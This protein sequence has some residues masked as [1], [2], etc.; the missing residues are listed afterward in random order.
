VWLF[1]EVYDNAGDTPHA[2]N[3]ATTVTSE[4]GTVVY[5][6]DGEHASSEFTGPHGTFRYRVRV[7][8]NDLEPGA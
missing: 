4:A 5:K 1:A 3:I 6:V 2:V 8:F 7:P